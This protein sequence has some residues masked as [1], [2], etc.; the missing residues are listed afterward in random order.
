MRNTRL[1]DLQRER[2]ARNQSLFRDVNERIDELTDDRLPDAEELQYV[3]ECLDLS[4]TER[5]AMPP[6]EYRRIRRGPAEFLVAP[7][8]EQ[9]DVEDVVDRRPRWLVVRKRGVAGR[10]ADEVVS[11][12]QTE[13]AS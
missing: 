2:A 6:Q 13:A 3:C 11:P 1:I 8:H 7:G 12:R 9:L 10:L 5:I 4:C